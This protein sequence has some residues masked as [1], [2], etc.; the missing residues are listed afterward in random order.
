VKSSVNPPGQIKSDPLRPG[1]HWSLERPQ[2]RQAPARLF[3]GLCLFVTLWEP[4][5]RAADDWRQFRGPNG[6]GVSTAQHLPLHWSESNNITWK[7]PIPGRGRSSPVI[8][9]DRLWMTT[10][11]EKGTQRKRIGSDDM[12]TSNSIGCQTTEC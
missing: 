6:D 2:P 10:A 11:V 9:G 4:P 12:Q 1:D 3:I 7:R 5:T 8:L